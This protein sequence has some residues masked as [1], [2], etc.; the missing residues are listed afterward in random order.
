MRQQET[1]AILR[2]ENVRLA[3]LEVLARSAALNRAAGSVGH[4][5]EVRGDARAVVDDVAGV[6]G[7]AVVTVVGTKD[8]FWF[9]GV[10]EGGAGEAG[11]GCCGGGFDLGGEGCCCRLHAGDRGVDVGACDTGGDDGGGAG[12][13]FG[14]GGGAQPVGYCF[15][16]RAQGCVDC[17]GAGGGRFGACEWVLVGLGELSLGMGMLTCHGGGIALGDDSLCA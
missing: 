9:A 7:N 11:G 6:V 13:G 10:E 12:E 1:V 5:L 14:G 3:G 17:F 8:V 2:A 4:D 15:G 16:G